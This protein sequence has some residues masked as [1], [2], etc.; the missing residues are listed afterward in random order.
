MNESTYWRWRAEQTEIVYGEA[1][2]RL[3]ERMIECVQEA[4]EC[5]QAVLYT[6]DEHIMEMS[7]EEVP[8]EA[9]ELDEEQGDEQPHSVEEEDEEQLTQPYP[10]EQK[11]SPEEKEMGPLVEEGSRTVME[12]VVGGLTSAV[13]ALGRVT[14]RTPAKQDEETNTQRLASDGDREAIQQL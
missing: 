2:G 10:V 7:R 11:E 8:V 1:N 14:G 12:S 5:V 9:H 3:Q 4:E 6:R 13:K